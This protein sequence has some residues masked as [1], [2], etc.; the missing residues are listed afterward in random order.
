MPSSIDPLAASPTPL[1]HDRRADGLDYGLAAGREFWHG[2]AR[3]RLE[4]IEADGGLD[5]R[6]SK[7]GALLV[8]RNPDGTTARPTVEWLRAEYAAG[9]LSSVVGSKETVSERQARFLSMDASSASIRDAKATWRHSLAWR[10]SSDR[11][12]CTDASCA[13]WLA[14]NYG[15]LP[16]DL[17]FPRPSGSSL[18]R[19]MRAMRKGG[20]RI[21]ALVSQAG[22]PRNHS[23]LP[24]EVDAALNEAAL[25]FYSAGPGFSQA[26]ADAHLDGLV[27]R[28]N[29]ENPGRSFRK[30]SR[31]SLRLRIEKLECI[32]TWEA[33]YGRDAAERKYRGA[34]EPLL[35]DHVLEICL[36][37]ATELEQIVT[38]DENRTIPC[39]KMRI[40]AVLDCLTHTLFGWHVYAGPNRAETS[41]Q[42]VL[43]CLEPN[44]FPPRMVQMH[45]QLRLAFGRPAAL[46]PDNEKAL[47][48]PDTLPGYNAAG[49]VV[50]PAPVGMPTAKAALER[51]FRTLKGILA[52]L[53]GTLVDPRRA[54]ELGFEMVEGMA[55]M[56]MHELR[57]HVAQAAAEHN[58]SAS[59]GLPG[60]MSPIEMLALRS[61]TRATD[62]FEDASFVRAN[63]CSH[64][65]A[66][67]TRNG[68]EKDGIRYRDA[69]AID[70]LYNNNAGRMGGA[71]KSHGFRMRARRADGDMDRIEI[72]D[73][74]AERW[75]VLPSTQ[76]GYTAGL[77]YW[78]HL[79]YAQ[80]AKR[81]REAFGSQT[82]RLKSMQ[83]TRR[84]HEEM[85]PKSKFRARAKMGALLASP[86]LRELAGKPLFTVS[87]IEQHPDTLEG[88]ATTPRVKHAPDPHTPSPSDG[89]DDDARFE[90]GDDVGADD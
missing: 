27:C 17:A 60:G 43:H 68:V 36:M 78:E 51:F 62:P 50:I 67:L 29:E 80:A 3:V 56:T 90:D 34:G 9:R 35:V 70:V 32:E 4:R 86:H 64:F 30:P 40:V 13:E 21:G 52:S 26:A 15:I 16:G 71:R 83:E 57:V 53:P 54:S 22:R 66:Y 8:V 41:A 74:H 77:S 72:Y 14:A 20:M 2:T 44:K 12:V 88:G 48:G 5:L 82:A 25:F 37:D 42:A 46:L 31:Q 28:L 58:V 10:A 49:M 19:W 65:E 6:S 59:K 76:P 89:W 38:F 11:V 73:E 7:T 24:P 18:R 84:L 87:P 1:A 63:L 23:Q 55:E 39:L 61:G 81:R 45:P 47:I 79:Q 69:A 85:L 33:K 75:T